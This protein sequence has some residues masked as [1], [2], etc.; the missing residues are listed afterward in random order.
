MPRSACGNSSCCAPQSWVMGEN[1]HIEMANSANPVI[2]IQR[3][4]TRG[5]S[6]EYNGTARIWNTPVENTASPICSAL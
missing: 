4:S 1:S 3:R 5:A 6:H 2:M